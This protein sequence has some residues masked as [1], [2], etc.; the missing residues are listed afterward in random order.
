[1]S[2]E[3]ISGPLKGRRLTP[4]LHARITHLAE[5]IDA[6]RKRV[7]AAGNGLT[8]TGLYNVLDA[9]RE[10]RLLT[11]KEKAIHEAGLVAVLQSLH[12]ELDAA[13]LAAY[14]WAD[15]A[16]PRDE[17]TLLTRLVALNADRVREEAAGTVRYLRPAWQDP[18]LRGTTDA[19]EIATGGQTA[20]A[21]DTPQP[22]KPAVPRPRTPY[23]NA[24][25]AI[26][27]R[28][29]AEAIA[30]QTSGDDALANANKEIR[31]LMV[32]EGVLS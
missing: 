11:A 12:D 13:V 19:A 30:G 31:E 1:M 3:A 25:E 4:V 29:V 24:V 7:L 27:G 5:N 6:H 26:Y 28:Y 16:L 8:L 14:G 21:I 22:Y 9:L 32:R 10:G 17:A 15:L 2:G 23:Y 20:L 18:A